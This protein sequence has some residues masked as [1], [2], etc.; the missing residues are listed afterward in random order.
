MNSKEALEEIKKGPRM[1]INIGDQLLLRAK[2]IDLDSNPHGPPAILARIG[3]KEIWIHFCYQ[4][5]VI[6]KIDK[7]KQG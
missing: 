4:K 5:E 1:D 3:N 6:A 2:V 7:Q